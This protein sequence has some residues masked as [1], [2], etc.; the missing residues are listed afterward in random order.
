MSEH[1]QV[2]IFLVRGKANHAGLSIP[3]HGLA[4]LSLRGARVV[5]WDAPSLPKGEPIFFDI[6]LE[7][8]ARALAHLQQPGLLN[9]EIIRQ[10]KA[11]RGWHLT[12]DA[13]DF[14]RTLRSRRSCDPED[15]NCVEWIVHALELGGLNLPDDVL[16]P[17][18]L[19]RWC[20]GACRRAPGAVPDSVVAPNDES[21]RDP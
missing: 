8:P 9:A 3:G 16:T 2:V 5:P 15:M 18:E 4:D 11:R 19:L 14:I 1:W 7:D 21:R 17:A 10:E 13:P 12:D 6:T 20:E